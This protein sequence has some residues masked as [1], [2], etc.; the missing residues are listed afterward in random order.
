MKLQSK[1]LMIMQ[2]KLKKKSKTYLSI[3]LNYLKINY[4]Y[5]LEN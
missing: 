2:P 5:K 3:I 4:I 1:N